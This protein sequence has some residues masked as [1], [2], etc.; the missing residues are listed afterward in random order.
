MKKS[1]KND[2]FLFL[3]LKSLVLGILTVL[4]KAKMSYQIDFIT[5]SY[6]GKDRTKGR[7]IE[8]S[9]WLKYAQKPSI[10]RSLDNLTY[11]KKKI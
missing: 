5:T 3:F 11:S 10:N 7:G 1:E 6:G 9:K 4:F 8:G 2:F